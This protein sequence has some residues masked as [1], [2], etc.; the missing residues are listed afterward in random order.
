ML[1][2]LPPAT[3]VLALPRGGVPVAAEIA[4][5]LRAPLDVIVVRKLGVPGHPEL[6]MGAIG[7]GGTR[8]VDQSLVD[9]LGITEHERAIVEL[10]E[11]D[12]LARRVHEFR[13]G[14]PPLALNERTVAVIDDGIATGSTARVACEIVWAAGAVRV[15]IAVP[16][17]PIGWEER[18]SDVADQFIAIA[19]PRQFKSI[20]SF[21]RDFTPTPSKEVVRLLTTH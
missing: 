12:E 13:A 5:Q 6:A 18:L 14:R 4:A 11:R 19:T 7:E 16:V 20:G 17:A 21:Y 10:R 3:I 15:V 9:R 2:H 1:S 8:F